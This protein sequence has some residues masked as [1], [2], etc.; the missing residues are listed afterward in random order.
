MIPTTLAIPLLLL[1]SPPVQAQAD[2]DIAITGMES[3]RTA[4]ENKRI[5]LLGEFTHGSHEVNIVKNQLI[6]VLHD[7]LGFDV[8]LFE[9][10]IGELGVVNLRRDEMDAQDML[11]AGVF[12]PW[13]TTEY[14]E[15]MNYV[16]QHSDLK[17]GGYDVQ[18]SGGAFS[19][20]LEEEFKTSGLVSGVDVAHAE[21]RFGELTRRM[22]SE[23]ID[24][25]M[26]S[27]VWE[28]DSLYAQLEKSLDFLPPFSSRFAQQ[29]IMNRRAY[30]DYYIQF[31]RDR[32]Y[33]A[34][35]AARDSLMAV[36]ARWFIEEI[37]PSAKI[38]FTGHNYHIGRYN[39]EESVMGEYLAQ[40][41]GNEMY[42]LGIFGGQGEYAN[43]AG[44]P[45]QTDTLVVTN[46]I[47]WLSERS[48]NLATFYDLTSK[49]GL[50]DN[51]VA[52]P[53]IVND[54]FINLNGGNELFLADSYDGILVIKSIS[55]S[56]R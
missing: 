50:E 35:F 49:N 40:E 32:N 46:D 1:F 48:E 36:N 22:R 38:I 5:V 53:V 43:N 11:H 4:V 6:Q 25:L 55:I 17:V 30:L 52:G 45:E 28:L 21:A 19:G 39:Q 14:L 12:G 42:A 54:S 18:R 13:R 37:F 8:L 24:S 23:D 47:K 44:R 33:R 20:W 16:N 31:K 29:T 51:W 9:S 34:R 10:G 7:S 41:F 2:E 56:R 15:L 27:D 26:V 3:F